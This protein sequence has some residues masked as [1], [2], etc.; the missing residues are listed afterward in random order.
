M[1]R[2]GRETK[3]LM[4]GQ[5]KTFLEKNPDIVITSFSNLKVPEM[6]ELRHSLKGVSSRYMVVKN[7]MIN[8][9]LKQ[10]KMED[11]LGMVDG[12][13]GMVFIGED[14]IKTSKILVD[15]KK[16]HKNLDIKGGF[17]EGSV[18]SFDKIKQ[19]ADLPPREILLAMVVSGLYS[20]VTG[21]VVSLA[22]IIRRFAYVINAI[23]EKGGN[24][25]G[26]GK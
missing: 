16:A 4:L 18:V 15:F 20:P 2:F 14:S 7:T 9:V 24:Q 13:C 21:F 22:G 3:E 11:T 12:M 5:I 10:Y 25:D 26:G 8:R 1:E 6:Q 17:L 19:L 23:K